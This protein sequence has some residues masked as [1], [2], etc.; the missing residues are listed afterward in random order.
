LGSAGDKVVVGAT[1]RDHR[2]KL[3]ILSDVDIGSIDTK[4]PLDGGADPDDLFEPVGP[5]CALDDA[6]NPKIGLSMPDDSMKR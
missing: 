2:E 5:L 4:G 3:E 6:L 1:D